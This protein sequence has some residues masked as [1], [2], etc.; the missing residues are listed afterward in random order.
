MRIKVRIYFTYL[1]LAC[2]S[3]FSKPAPASSP[4]KTYQTKGTVKE[5][6]LDHHSVVIRHDRI[7]DYMPPMTMEFTVLDPAELNGISPGDEITFHLTVTDESHWIDSLRV[8]KSSLGKISQPWD[9]TA[10]IRSTAVQ[11][12]QPMP[13]HEFLTENGKAVRF[14]DFRGTVLA[15]TFFFSRC[16]LPDFCPLM[17]KNFAQARN[18]LTTASNGNT[19]WH[20]LSISFD[21]EFDKPAVLARYARTYRGEDATGWTFAAASTY[22][23][24]S[25]ANELDLRVNRDGGGF[26]HNLRTIILDPF[27]RIYRQFE[28]NRWTAQDLAEEMKKAALTEK[29]A[30]AATKTPSFAL[31]PVSK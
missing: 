31:P 21:P 26:S 13:D 12:G 15:F 1:C 27:G 10:A 16:P 18:L 23:L 20:F 28:G 4:V 7:P 11:T 17:S 30:S 22:T 14:S 29:P 24:S 3:V 8:I 2:F 6:S 25:L 5:L 9:P 19:N